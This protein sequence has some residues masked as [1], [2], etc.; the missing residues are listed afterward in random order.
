M[1]SSPAADRRKDECIA[2]LSHALRNPLAQIRYALPLLR[3]QR[4][5]DFG[6]R[7]IEVVTRQANQLSR[8]LRPRTPV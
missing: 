3:S 2:L 4:L 7:A 1:R 5:D 6:S 8:L